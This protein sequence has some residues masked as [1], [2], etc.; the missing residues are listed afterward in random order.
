MTILACFRSASKR[1]LAQDQT[2][3]FTGT[4]AFQLK[5]QEIFA[6]AA[7]DLAQDQDWRALTRLCQLPSDGQTQDFDLPDDY[8]RMLINGAVQSVVWS[9]YYEAMPDLNEWLLI[10]DFIPS[11]IPGYWNISG[12]QMHL[13]P[14]PASEDVPQFWYI[15]KNIVTAIDG[16]GKTSFERDDDSFALDE[17]LLTLSAI[18]R[19]KQAEGLDYQEDMQNYEIRKSQLGTK[20]KGSTVIRPGLRNSYRRGIWSLSR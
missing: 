3:L 19:W 17:P 15:T 7:R 2:S 11:D 9:V 1:L 14:A 4:S 18:W 20:D 8:G 12:G 10:K 13:I 16:T 5:M 6:D